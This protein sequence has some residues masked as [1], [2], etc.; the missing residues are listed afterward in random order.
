MDEYFRK[1]KSI[2]TI[3]TSLGSPVSSEYVVTFALEG[4][5]D[6]YDHVCG[7][8]HH[9]DNF[10][11]LKIACLMLITEDM[12]LMSKSQSLHA[13]LLHP[14]GWHL[15]GI[16]VTWTQFGKKQD[17]IATLHEEA[18]SFAYKLW[19]RRQE[20]SRRRHNSKA[21][22]SAKLLVDRCAR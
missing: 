10:P 5:P 9:R 14:L 1:I 16:H 21:T 20:F 22:T 13:V 12:W 6:K 18:Q 2:A 11:D 8:M 3:L 4:L 15:E 19:R 7:I 17:K